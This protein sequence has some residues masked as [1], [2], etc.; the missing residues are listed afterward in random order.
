M[1]VVE[2]MVF[3]GIGLGIVV[4]AHQYRALG[5]YTKAVGVRMVREIF[6]LGYRLD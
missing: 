1:T 5:S 6:T 2:R 4:K 3:S